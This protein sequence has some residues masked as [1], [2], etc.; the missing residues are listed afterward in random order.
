MANDFH[1]PIHT[2]GFG[3][4]DKINSEYLCNIA[5]DHDGMFGYIPDAAHLGTIFVN[6]I[7]N[8]LSTCVHNSEL[9]LK[10]QGEGLRIETLIVGGIRREIGRDLKSATIHLGD[11]RYGQDLEFLIVFKDGQ[12]P[13]KYEAELTYWS[14]SKKYGLVVTDGQFKD[15]EIEDN[16]PHLFRF[17]AIAMIQ[18]H[19]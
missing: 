11:L 4:Y 9:K 5:R 8:I 16:L 3:Q 1:V 10:F 17:E 7:A 19:L 18:A 13:A 6:G 12:V 14:R 2:F 15:C